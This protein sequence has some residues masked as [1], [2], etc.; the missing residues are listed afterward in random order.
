MPKEEYRNSSATVFRAPQFE[1]SRRLQQV[2]RL[3]SYIQSRDTNQPDKCRR[4]KVEDHR[5]RTTIALALL[6]SLS[7]H[8]HEPRK[9]LQHGGPARNGEGG[10][11]HLPSR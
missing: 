6:A 4:T 7:P 3:R 10:G 1:S 9:R 8:S 11:C 2:E 5:E